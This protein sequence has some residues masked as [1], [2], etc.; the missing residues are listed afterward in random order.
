ML[1]NFRQ[2]QPRILLKFCKILAESLLF[3]LRQI[4][5][6][7]A[8]MYM[9]LKALWEAIRPHQWLKNVFVLSGLVF[10]DAWGSMEYVVRAF[11]AT[12]AFI[13]VSSAGYLL[14]D[15]IDCNVDAQH[16]QKKHRSIVSGKLSVPAA[17]RW[18]FLL[19][20]MGL[21]LGF[22]LS[23]KAFLVLITYGILVAAYSVGLKKIP[24]IELLC[25][26]F[27]FMLRILLGTWGIGIPPS[28]WVMSC[29]FLLALFLILAKR[30]SEQSVFK[31]LST[32]V[33]NVLN[34]YNELLLRK[35]V[36]SVALLCIAV[37]A[38][39]AFFHGLLLTIIFV[40]LGI[41][42]YLFLFQLRSQQG[43]ELDVA[44]E[45]FQDRILQL[46]VSF[47]FLSIVFI[48]TK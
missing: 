30:S 37:Y 5:C 46:T 38:C 7:Q 3:S 47:W 8:L 16:P 45:F 22:S 23:W 6:K 36:Y 40:T 32:P 31:H 26:V 29:G 48:H 28:V 41:F 19:L 25:I 24:W 43:I 18:L 39:Y 17:I 1:P 4:N 15:L 9:H 14:N 13:L 34:H 12:L 44:N 21:C 2:I 10:S 27:G 20:M 11:E 35:A 33:R 42:R